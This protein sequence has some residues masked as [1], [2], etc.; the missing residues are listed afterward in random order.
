MCHFCRQW[1]ETANTKKPTSLTPPQRE[2]A[3]PVC[4]VTN[5]KI[6]QVTVNGLGIGG[7]FYFPTITWD[8]NG[9]ME[10][11]TH[12]TNQME[13]LSIF[14]NQNFLLN[15]I[16]LPTRGNN[17]LDLI[18]TND[19]DSCLDVE[20]DINIKFSDHNL[21][22]ISTSLSDHKNSDTCESNLDYATEIPYYNWRYGTE[23]DWLKYENFLDNLNWL[24]EKYPLLCLGYNFP[25]LVSIPDKL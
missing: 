24:E 13:K 10:I 19:P 4:F 5:L 20:I 14:M 15:M 25:K 16:K 8:T 11:D 9:R 23:L 12:L 21:V 22:S 3:A 1:T 6:G 7:D 18:L 2:R 17:I